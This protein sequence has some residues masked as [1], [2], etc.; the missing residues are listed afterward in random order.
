MPFPE[1]ED[2]D[3]P[4]LCFILLNGGRDHEVS[5]GS[6]YEPLADFFRLTKHERNDPRPDGR[7]EPEWHNR[8]QW[9][10]QRP[11]N[12]GYLDGSRDGFWRLTAAGLQRAER[13][14]SKYE[15]LKR[16]VPKPLPS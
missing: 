2:M 13:V 14:V 5:A 6:T 3:D 4:L 12:H 7:S 15:T 8:V 16:W 9:A 10:R 11:I 1:Y